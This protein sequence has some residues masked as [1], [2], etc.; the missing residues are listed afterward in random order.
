MSASKEG[1]FTLMS[2]KH[3]SY[4]QSLDFP[5]VLFLEMSRRDVLFSFSIYGFIC[6]TT[7]GNDWFYMQYYSRKWSLCRLISV[8]EVLWNF[9]VK[10]L[11]SWRLRVWFYVMC[12]Q[13]VCGYAC[14]SVGFFWRGKLWLY[15]SFAQRHRQRLQCLWHGHV[16]FLPLSTF[17][18]QQVR[19]LSTEH[20]GTVLIKCI[21]VFF[22]STCMSVV[23]KL[24]G[25]RT[26]FQTALKF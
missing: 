19:T 2:H 1:C 4:K 17:Y 13:H 11:W 3:F 16:L 6:D 26:I 25:F 15:L 8:A 18:H 5:T 21:S 7:Q 24:C 9:F 12:R 23:W 14:T 22:M 10:L 20:L